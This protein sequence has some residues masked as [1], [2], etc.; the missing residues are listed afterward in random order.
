VDEVA[1]VLSSGMEYETPAGIGKMIS[2]PDLGNDRTV[3]SITTYYVKN[4]VDGEPVLLDSIEMEEA[5]GY[6]QTLFP[7]LQ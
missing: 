4:I 1:A 6:F 5:L 7:P 2:R 3:D